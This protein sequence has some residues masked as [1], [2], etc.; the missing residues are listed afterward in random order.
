MSLMAELGEGPPPQQVRPISQKLL[1]FSYFLFRCL[2]TAPPE[3]TA[4]CLPMLNSLH[5]RLR[6]QSR[7]DK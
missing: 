5:Q 7:V 4:Q 1:H 6:W 3:I 2:R